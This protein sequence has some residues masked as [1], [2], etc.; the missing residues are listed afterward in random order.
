MNKDTG[1][2]VG[3]AVCIAVMLI[4]VIALVFYLGGFGERIAAWLPSDENGTEVT[5][6]TDNINEEVSVSGPVGGLDFVYLERVPILLRLNQQIM[7]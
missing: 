6:Q 5:T 3:I 4:G 2:K 1:R 7:L